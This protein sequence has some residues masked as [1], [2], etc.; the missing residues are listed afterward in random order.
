MN[1]IRISIWLGFVF[2][3]TGMWAAEKSTGSV[4]AELAEKREQLPGAYQEFEV[5][6]IL[7]TQSASQASTRRVILELA[8]HK[9]REQLISGSGQYVRMFDGA[10][11]YWME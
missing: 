6:T 11:T 9:W 7:K 3:N 2:L 8:G 10:D 4:W 5:S 1:N